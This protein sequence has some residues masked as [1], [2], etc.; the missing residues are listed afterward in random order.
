M[1]RGLLESGMTTRGRAAAFL[2]ARTRLERLVAL[3]RGDRLF[4]SHH[5]YEI[6]DRH[7]ARF[8]HRRPV[9]FLEIG[10]GHGG[11]LQ[12]W[13]RHF[14]ASARI[15][16]IDIRPECRRFEAR[17]TAIEIGS[18]G[19]PAFLEAVALRHGP[20]DIVVDDGSHYFDHQLAA[21]R[22]LFSHIKPDGIYACEDLCSSYW[23]HEFGGGLRKEGTFAE[24]L[25]TLVDE[26][27]GWFWREDVAAAEALTAHLYG[28][29]FYPALAI[30]EKRAMPHPV[31]VHVGRE[32]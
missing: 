14:G 32:P 24:F 21:F 5:F 1:L 7:F 2:S 22:A 31:V 8:P 9:T 12:L 18:Q 6:Y 3:H 15:V 11:S 25:K 30:V 26:L 17:G 29:H 27:N 19:D 20:F 13:R 28:V 10:L 16:G 23:E 4:K